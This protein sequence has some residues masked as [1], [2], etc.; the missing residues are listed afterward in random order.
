MCALGGSETLWVEEARRRRG[1][2]VLLC[3]TTTGLTIVFPTPKLPMGE[4]NKP[5]KKERGNLCT[6]RETRRPGY[7]P[8]GTTRLVPGKKFRGEKIPGKKEGPGEWRE[9]ALLEVVVLRNGPAGGRKKKG[10]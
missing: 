3:F 6:Q 5:R 10:F 9:G 8:E 7:V 1:K 4:S 2:N